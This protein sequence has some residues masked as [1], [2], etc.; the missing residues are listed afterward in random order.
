MSAEERKKAKK[1]FLEER[2]KA[3][4]HRN[5]IVKMLKIKAKEK[6]LEAAQ[7]K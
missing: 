4:K 5:I 7:E 6:I 2:E 3:E 1:Y